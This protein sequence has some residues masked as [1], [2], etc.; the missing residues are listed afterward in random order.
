MSRL[1]RP[2]LRRLLAARLLR[3]LLASPLALA[4]A[5]AQA[6]PVVVFAAASLKTALD[7]IETAYEAASGEA[8]A[9]SY[10]GSSALARQIQ[11]GAPAQVFVSANQG[12]MDQLQQDGLIAEDSRADLLRNSVV[13][14]AHGE[15]GDAAPAAGIAPSIAPDSDLLGAL[16]GGRLAMALVEAVPAG[17]YGKAALTSLGLW[18]TVAPQVA[19]ADNVR[20]ALALVAAGEAPLGVVYATDAAA[21]PRVHVLARFPADSH[22]PVIYPATVT[23]QGDAPAARAFL[24]HLQ[25][26]EAQAIFLDEGFA[27]PED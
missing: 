9:I 24:A 12:W 23:A 14:I 26:P 20:A 10:A 18:E 16:D 15:A 8:L 19:Q 4:P 3:A 17:I 13:L 6:E 2:S 1:P 22:P 7:R 27:L 25:S 5:L 11:A 21:E